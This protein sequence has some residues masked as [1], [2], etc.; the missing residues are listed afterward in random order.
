MLYYCE[1]KEQVLKD[2]QS[3]E[4]GL[5]E[6]EAEERLKENGKNALE[7]PKGKSLIRRFLEQLTDPMIIILIVAAAVSGVGID[8]QRKYFY[9]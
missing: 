3:R 8:K 1:E 5:S 4:N 6:R 7:A 2:V 9:R